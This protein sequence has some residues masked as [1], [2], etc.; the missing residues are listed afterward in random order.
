MQAAASGDLTSRA[1]HDNVLVVFGGLLLVMLQLARRHRCARRACGNT[2]GAEFVR[3]SCHRLRRL[4]IACGDTR[5]RRTA[6]GSWRHGLRVV[7]ADDDWTDRDR[8]GW[9]GHFRSG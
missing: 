1:S 2:A 3:A 8:S 4:R 6:H 9:S 5:V 7:I